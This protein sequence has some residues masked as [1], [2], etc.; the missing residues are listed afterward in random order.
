MTDSHDSTV[1]KVAHSM[2]IPWPSAEEGLLRQ[3]ADA[4]DAA[5]KAIDEQ[6][7]TCTAKVRTLT[8]HNTGG[9]VEAF[10][11]FWGKFDGSGPGGGAMPAT[12]QACRDMS[13]AL[14]QYASEVEK[15]KDSI[16]HKIEIA[17]AALVAGTVLA[18]ISFGASAAAAT[19]V[20]EI[21]VEFAAAAGI[22]LSE[23]VAGLI[24]T[25]LVGAAFGAVESMAVDSLVVQPLSIATHEQQGFSFSQMFHWAEGGAAGGAFAGAASSG[26]KALPALTE[27]TSETAP[28]IS[29]TLNGLT[30]LTTTTP[31]R[32]A[33]DATVGIGGGSLTTVVQG[34]HVTGLDLL[35][36][37][38]GGAAGSR[39]GTVEVRPGRG[40]PSGT[41]EVGGPGTGVRDVP[42]PGHDAAGSQA[43][44]GSGTP[45]GMPLTEGDRA[46]L[47][48]YTTNTEDASGQKPYARM[49]QALRSGDVP[50]D[51]APR[52]DA[53]STALAKLPSHEGPVYRGT[54]L[55]PGA[56]DRYVPG[57]AVTEPAF[58]SSSTDPTKS[59]EG[60]T[61]FIIDSS[62]GK[63]V[64]PYSHFQGESE[65]LFD[66]HTRFEV[67][68]KAWDADLH[69]W[70][71]HMREIP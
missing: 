71:V 1:E 28:T 66:Q 34:D 40:G 44:G 61:V 21:I 24:G 41:D 46:A 53:V 48:D 3:A 36:G 35:S 50:T 56:L 52:I 58:T 62:H 9:G 30:R 12:A 54:N 45:L 60:N 29:S 15:T 47:S 8:A 11:T 6:R 55:P 5:A 2:G 59:F 57:H 20:C 4:F 33:A 22:A 49:N 7:Q 65:V 68:D 27:A 32:I 38:I 67:L 63:D 69:K 70:V 14:R 26:L 43:N 19:A 51:L 64:A 37:A 23:T 39:K 42:P 16:R 25:V 10:G 17:G 18:V 13:K 31:G